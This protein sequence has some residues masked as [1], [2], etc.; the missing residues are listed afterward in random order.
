MD[1]MLLFMQVILFYN[2]EH[3]SLLFFQGVPVAYLHP[4]ILQCTQ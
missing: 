2:S 4:E 1:N 3:F